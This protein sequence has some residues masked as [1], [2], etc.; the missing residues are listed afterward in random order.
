MITAELCGVLAGVLHFAG[1][2]LYAGRIRCGE[3]V[4]HGTSWAMR[5]YGAAV[6]LLIFAEAGIPAAILIQPTVS[7][8]CALVV[9]VFA[10]RTGA[11]LRPTC[12]DIRILAADLVLLAA[13]IVLRQLPPDPHG[14]L[15]AQTIIAVTVIRKIVPYVPVLRMITIDRQFERPTPWAVWALGYL[16]LFGAASLSEVDPALTM[17]PLAVFTAHF[18]IWVLLARRTTRPSG[19]RPRDVSPISTASVP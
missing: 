5:C 7:G 11:W 1:F 13:Y 17:Y 10:L 6:H 12:A 18:A 19:K 2:M 9:T 15:L 8:L 4:P 3:I 14:A 16:A